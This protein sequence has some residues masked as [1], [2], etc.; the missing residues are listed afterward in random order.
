MYYDAADQLR[1]VQHTSLGPP[2]NTTADAGSWDEYWYDAL[3]RRVLMR[4]RRND[5]SNDPNRRDVIDRFVWDGDQLL[6]EIRNPGG[7]GDPLD[8]TI[9]SGSR[10]A[11]VVG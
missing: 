7:P 2:G 1:V 9:T 6:Y 3:G 4:E 8:Q 5:L 10:F 11:G